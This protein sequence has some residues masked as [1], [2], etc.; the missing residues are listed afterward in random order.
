[1]KKLSGWKLWVFLGVSVALAAAVFLLQSAPA[2]EP[3]PA[4]V[5]EE[6][7][8]GDAFTRQFMEPEGGAAGDVSAPG[9]EGNKGLSGPGAEGAGAGLEVPAEATRERGD[10]ITLEAALEESAGTPLQPDAGVVEP[11]AERLAASSTEDGGELPSDGAAAVEEAFLDEVT[12]YSAAVEVPASERSTEAAGRVDEAPVVELPVE[13]VE[14]A[15]GK[16]A[17]GDA[18]SGLGGNR[19]PASGRRIEFEAVGIR[20]LEVEE[21]AAVEGEVVPGQGPVEALRG[22]LAMRLVV[23]QARGGVRVLRGSLGY[24]VPMV[25]RQE[26]PDQITGGVYVP[27]HETY[28]IVRA[29]HWTI[30]GEATPEPVAP[31]EAA[32]VEERPRALLPWLWEKLRRPRDDGGTE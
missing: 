21:K 29:G 11:Q 32:G 15:Q 31:G 13:A 24:R 5:G 18:L 14:A 20:D 26:V 7:A 9:S 28:V 27:A 17:A 19:V 8:P 2:P 30:E 16:V 10:V 25:V 23:P 6:G 3:E 1:M 12:L 22:N 4:A